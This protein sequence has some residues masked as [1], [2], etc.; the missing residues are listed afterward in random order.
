M[1]GVLFANG[2]SPKPLFEYW[3][4]SEDREPLLGSNLIS[5]ALRKRNSA[6][7]KTIKAARR[8]RHFRR[9]FTVAN[10]RD[11]PKDKQ[12][13]N[14]LWKVQELLDEL[15]KQAKD[16]W[17][18][19]KFV[20]IDE[21]TIGFQGASGMKLRIS[22]KRKGDGFQCDAVCDAG[23]IFSFY[24]RHGPPPNVGDQYKSLELSP[25]ARRVVWLASRLPNKWTRIY[26]DNLFNSQKLF[27][28]LHTAE[29]LAHDVAR[30][31]GRG[32][33]PS[34]IQ[35]EEKNKDRAEKLRGTTMAPSST[36]LTCALIFLLSRCTIR[37]RSTFYRLRLNVCVCVC[38]FSTSG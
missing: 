22:Y 32:V 28:A 19:G 26:M 25:T 36:I 4:C 34:I 23:Y 1:F 37:S 18:P 7:G 14:P 35:K 31:N 12:R 3:F 11:S 24:F 6:T 2:L 15:N 27:T 13:V 29:A 17:V 38:V 8:W 30:A 5:H 9:Y 33:P 21:Q 16:M 10:Y 20:A